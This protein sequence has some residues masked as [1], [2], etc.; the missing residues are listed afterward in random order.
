MGF[1]GGPAR[2]LTTLGLRAPNSLRS[3]QKGLPTVPPAMARAP[4]VPPVCSPPLLPPQETAGCVEASIILNLFQVVNDLG[5]VAIPE[6]C[7]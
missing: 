2:H 4:S 1:Q 7:T 6:R 5:C 3:S